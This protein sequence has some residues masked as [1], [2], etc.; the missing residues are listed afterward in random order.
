[1]LRP[2]GETGAEIRRSCVDRQLQ[3]LLAGWVARSEARSSAAFRTAVPIGAM[4]AERP[5]VGRG[6]LALARDPA[7]VRGIIEP[8]AVHDPCSPQQVVEQDVSG[9]CGICHFVSQEKAEHCG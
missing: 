7:A 1:L 9:S 6:A 4:G 5:N 3:V 2:A 8:M